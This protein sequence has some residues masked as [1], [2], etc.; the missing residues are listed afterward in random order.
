MNVTVANPGGTS[1]TSASDQ[2]MYVTPGPA[3]TVTKLSVTKGPPAGGTSVT[4]TGTSF[5]GVTAVKFGSF[6]AASFKVDS[7]TSVAAVSPAGTTGT[8]EVT[9][10]TP[11][12][13]SGITSKDRFEFEA[14]TVTNVS[15]NT[16]PKA[17]GTPVTVTGSGFALGSGATLVKF[18]AGIAIEVNCTSTATCTMLA[19]AA[20]KTGT[21]DVTATVSKKT[22]KKQT[23]DQ[24]T[25]D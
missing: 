16:G 12:G 24:Y 19:P 11:N 3:P 2:F 7:S 23:A 22:S 13:E 25:Y 18:G 6:N 8:V 1:T 17:G 14:P 4:I 9:V 21:V 20:A 5:I 15:P 10:T